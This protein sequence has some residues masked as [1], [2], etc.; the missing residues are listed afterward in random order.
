MASILIVDDQPDIRRVLVRLVRLAG[1][2]PAAAGGGEEA[3]SFLQSHVPDLVL[4]DV[5]MPDVDGFA[6]L[7]SIRRDPQTAHVRVVMFSALSAD[8]VVSR[9]LR[10]GADD[11]WVKGALDVQTLTARVTNQ[12]T[13][14]AAGDAAN[15][16][17]RPT[18]TC[19]P[20]PPPA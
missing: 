5:M 18:G 11:F 8:D 19:G 12:W 17:Y 14:A 3:L 7:R 20:T 1:H 16:P 2:D 6:V 13:A 4:L 15:T 9:A 10:E